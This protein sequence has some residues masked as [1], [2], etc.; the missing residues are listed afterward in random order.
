MRYLPVLRVRSSVLAERALHRRWCSRSALQVFEV[1]VIIVF[2]RFAVHAYVAHAFYDTKICFCE[3]VQRVFGS[4]F[5]SVTFI[6]ICTYSPTFIYIFF[7][8]FANRVMP[9]IRRLFVLLIV[10]RVDL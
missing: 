7:F 6:Y 4:S 9:F 3:L 8:F 2:A 10:D 5:T 1:L